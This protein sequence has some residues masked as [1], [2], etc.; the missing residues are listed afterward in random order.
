MKIKKVVLNGFKRFH[1]L[2]IDLG[3]NP[4]KVIALVGPNGCG[5]SS[6][7]DAFEQKAA[8]QKGLR[9]NAHE[10]KAFY[11][12]KLYSSDLTTEHSIQIEYKDPNQP[13][14]KTSY[15]IR[16][17]YRFTGR[18]NVTTL[19]QKSDITDDDQRPATSIDMDRR[20]QDNY[21]RL[22]AKFLTDLQTSDLSGK[23]LKESI[24]KEINDVL[25]EILDIKITSLGNIAEK[26]EG[27]LFF[28]KGTSE[29]F[30]YDNLSS[31]EKEVLDIIIDLVLKRD[32]YKDTV[33]CIDEPELHL[34]TAV[35]R[36]LLIEIVKLIPDNCQL[37]IATHSVG[38]L[39]GL[40][41]ELSSECQIIDLSEHNFDQTTHI[42]PIKISRS[43]WQR[44][45]KTALEDL[46][47][48]I[49]P[50]KMVYCEGRIEPSTDGKELG[51]DALIYNEI[52]E[53][54]FPGI[55]FVSGGGNTEPH[56]YAEF[57]IM[58]FSK[59][60]RD[61]KII[62]LADRDL[63]P[64]GRLMTSKERTTWLAEGGIRRMLKR[65]EIENYIF[66]FEIVNLAFPNVTQAQYSEIVSDIINDDIK[67]KFVEIRT[68]CGNNNSS[69]KEFSLML[70]K[71]ITPDTA[72]Y[73]E[74]ID[75]LGLY[76]SS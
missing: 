44:I 51:F 24:I 53:P 71:E 29:N 10:A 41:E 31:G 62:H 2:T 46:T 54:Y 45:F 3:E 13:L 25:Q 23:D 61:I 19:N 32:I 26:G 64:D 67:S 49:A 39:R 57:A 66:D 40:Q 60:L 15:L 52:F 5:K 16:S 42:E 48:L 20:L 11:S 9:I 12:K 34:N 74:L 55:T 14:S 50:Q 47:G 18:I 65:R 28:E 22:F 17:A 37:W 72:V 38:F 4:K 27:K 6:I 59:V 7:F 56:I 63:N 58:V 8:E 69:K 43:N 73:K 33:F 75:C 1:A 30:P 70:A 76:G 36:K 68:L 35:Q 21:E